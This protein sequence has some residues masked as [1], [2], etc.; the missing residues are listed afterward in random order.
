MKAVGK[1]K[2]KAIRR[3]GVRRAQSRE[4]AK[5]EARQKPGK[6]SRIKDEFPTSTK[7]TFLGISPP[8]EQKNVTDRGYSWIEEEEERLY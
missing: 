4:C 1:G 7:G 5:A 8:S 6:R 2:G 3:H